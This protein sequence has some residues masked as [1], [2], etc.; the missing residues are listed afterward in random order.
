MTQHWDFVIDR[1]DLSRTGVRP[2]PAP[3]SVALEDGEVLLD[4]ERFALTANNITYGVYGDRLGYWRFFPAEGDWGRIPVWGFATVRRSTVETIPVGTRLFGYLPMATHLVTRLERRPWGVVDVSPHRAEL[5]P[6]YNS[7]VEAA[8]GPLDDQI[9]LLRP[10]FLTAFLLDDFFA[11]NDDFGADVFILSSASSKTA[12]GLAWLLA[13]RGRR[14]IGL[15]SD[16]NA[17]FVE[18]VGHY[19]ET[20]TYAAFAEAPVD[21]Q[22]VF[23]DFAGAPEVVAAVHHGL[24]DRLVHSAVV[25]STHQADGAVGP[26]R[27]PGPRPTFFFAPDRLRQRS[28][29]WGGEVLN[30]RIQA[31]LEDFITANAWLE[32]TTHAGPEALEA[33]Y[34]AVLAGHARP[35]DGHMVTPG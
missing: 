4:L 24:G 21:G 28:K 22:A 17:A 29:D 23:V 8:P 16:R 14:V 3:D 33:A 12:L 32:V 7:L 35:E 19:A 25:G 15:T 27:L 26:G 30:A 1:T 5:P 11:G 10:L 34:R 2:L 13:R 31:A 9:A 20:R 18:G 6:A